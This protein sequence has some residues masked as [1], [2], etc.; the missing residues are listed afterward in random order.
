MNTK[1]VRLKS[2]ED[3]IC[4]LITEDDNTITAENVIV[5]VPQGQGQLG[6]APWSP[7]AKEKIALNIARDYVV[8]ITEP[9]ESIV[10]QYEGL[11][12]TVITPSKKL[13]V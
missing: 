6:F 4:D 3:I 11:F 8:C 13:I 10:E 12:A 1:L 2:G 9:N 5:A 7:L